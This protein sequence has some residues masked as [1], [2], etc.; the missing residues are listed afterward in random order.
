MPD[1]L[2]ERLR[3]R[4]GRLWARLTGAKRRA[5]AAL[6]A[7][8][9]AAVAAL[10]PGDLAIDLGANLGDVSAVL[11][12]TGAEVIAFE[13]DPYAFGRL[14]E[15]LGK[16]ANV[17]LMNA[18]AGDRAGVMPLYRHRGFDRAPDRRSLASSLLADHADVGKAPAAQVEVHDFAAFV[19]GLGRDVA[20]VKIDI[21]GA[22]VA[23]MEALLAHPAAA[24]IGRI[25]VETHERALP[26]LA[27]RTRALKART[28][29]LVRPTVNWDWH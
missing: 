22:E 5:R 28:R 12:A 10:G 11:A 9:R 6:Q 17:R 1:Y 18:A 13:P 27:A 15:R 26:G 20:L 8:F 19:A 29:G 2:G 16:L 24:R 4:L 25:F 21:E 23:L 7:E 3:H 14:A